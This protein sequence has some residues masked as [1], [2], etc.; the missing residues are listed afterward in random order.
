MP[1][2]TDAAWITVAKVKTK[3]R[4]WRIDSDEVSFSA[5]LG[6]VWLIQCRAWASF[7]D[8]FYIIK[9]D[10]DVEH[11]LSPIGGK[12]PSQIPSIRWNL[13]VPAKQR[14]GLKPESGNPQRWV[15]IERLRP[16]EREDEY[17]DEE[18]E[19]ASEED[20]DTGE[21]LYSDYDLSEEGSEDEDCFVIEVRP[22]EGNG[23]SDEVSSMAVEV[24]SQSG[25]PVK[26]VTQNFCRAVASPG[27][28]NN[29]GIH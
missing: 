18:D 13:D 26:R 20:E 25:G 8:N 29:L 21:D 14:A 17:E 9:G 7:E 28:L 5:L 11:V 16:G 12:V 24:G 4:F 10:N 15:K 27:P 6:R 19:E 22:R 1:G 2:Y 23:D 3:V